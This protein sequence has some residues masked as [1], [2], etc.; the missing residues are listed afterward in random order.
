MRYKTQRVEGD[1]RDRE[2]R[3]IQER[4]R[5]RRKI[6]EIERERERQKRAI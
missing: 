2:R 4:E 1:T 3:V 6:Q 5:E